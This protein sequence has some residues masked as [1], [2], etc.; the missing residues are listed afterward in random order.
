MTIVSIDPKPAFPITGREPYLS[1]SYGQ[2]GQRRLSIM[3]LANMLNLL[4][5]K[6]ISLAVLEEALH[7][8]SFYVRY[9]AAKKLGER[10]DR[11]ARVVV[12]RTLTEG[13]A[14]SRASVARHLYGFSWFSA[15]PLL[16][17]ALQD[18]DSRV[19]EGAVYALCDVRELT[20]YQLLT[21]ILQRE[22]D[23]VRMAAAWGL[24]DCQDPAAVPVLEAVMLAED[25]EV[26]IKALEALA[27]TDNMAAMPILRTA[28]NDAEPD[29][30]YA[31]TLSLLELA[32]EAWLQELS[33][34]IGRA[35][36]ETLRQILR[37][38]FHATNYLKID[39]G[40]S[41]A[42]DMMID[43]LEAALF[44][45][46]PAARMAVIWPLAWMKHA[47]MPAVLRQAYYREQ[48]S[49][50]KAHTLRV[51]VS[52]MSEVSEELLQDALIIN[53]DQVNAVAQQ[54]VRD[55]TQ[56]SRVPT[57]HDETPP[58]A[59]SFIQNPPAAET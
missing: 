47:R 1:T 45:E 59:T 15:Q 34:I 6:A 30:K 10:G 32:G 42:A 39:V 37:A 46:L 31:A 48:D 41:T 36:G 33:G 38:F 12:Q 3:G 23:A 50:V 2:Q 17:Q 40:A 29:V 43:S 27:A 26:R 49:E 54:I 14:P 25:P 58:T 13:T 4:P 28:M 55:R 8:D 22:N 35:S 56:T 7:S 20:A 11:D 21:D 52:L 51:A 57:R 18:Q 19:R 44:D 16:Q 9:S 53:D 24:R 5:A